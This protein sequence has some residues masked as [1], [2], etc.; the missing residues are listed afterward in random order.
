MAPTN[1]IEAIVRDHVVPV[2]HGDDL[3]VVLR[4]ADTLATGGYGTI[5]FTDR[6]TT[7]LGTFAKVV[8]RLAESH[9]DVTIGAGSIVTADVARR[10]VDCGAQFIVGPATSDGVASACF[11][12]KVPYVPGCGTLTEILRGH[13]MGC[14][15]VKL[16][17]AM[18]VGG[19]AFLSAV[20][21]PCPDIRVMPTGGIESSEDSLRAW[22]EAG[23]VAI[24]LGSLVPQA[25]VEAGDWA[26]LASH[27]ATVRANVTAALNPA[28]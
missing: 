24:G 7:A 10:Y 17:P 21:G 14:E 8:P 26:G 13:E 5:E 16:F 18:A 4:I 25:L 15:I 12:R 11:D 22:F 3:D 2:F 27:V 6:S 1:A 23:A 20:R 19:P 9:P 28:D